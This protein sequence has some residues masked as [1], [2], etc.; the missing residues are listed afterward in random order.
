MTDRNLA[1]EARTRAWLESSYRGALAHAAAH[2]EPVWEADGRPRCLTRYAFQEIQRKLK[3]FRWLDRLRF[4]SVLDVGSGFDIYPNLVRARYGA[5]ACFSDFVHM[6]N[7]PYGGVASGKLD[8]AVTLNAARCRSPTAPS[9]WCSP[10]RCSST[11]SARSK[12][13]PSC[14]G[15][16]ARP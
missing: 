11:W 2:H 7:L 1:V 10:P 14:C 6:M 16:A 5:E 13:S 9:M 4:A 8:R 3:I 12:S 15:S